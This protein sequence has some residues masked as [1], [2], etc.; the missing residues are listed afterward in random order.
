MSKRKNPYYKITTE[1]I[2]PGVKESEWSETIH[3]RP[4]KSNPPKITVF[5]SKKKNNDPL[6]GLAKL[7]SSTNEE[8]D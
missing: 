8:D 3:V 6:L 7:L 5:K 4:R 2:V 1:K